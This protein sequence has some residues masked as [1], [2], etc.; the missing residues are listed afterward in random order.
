MRHRAAQQVSLERHDVHTLL[1]LLL[2][3]DLLF[4]Y[5]ASSD[6]VSSQINNL[7]LITFTGLLEIL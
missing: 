6:Q 7:S 2:H 4:H 5:F 3:L 1:F